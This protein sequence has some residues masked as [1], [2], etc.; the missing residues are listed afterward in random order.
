MVACSGGADSTALACALAAATDRL[1]IAHVV[2][3]LRPRRAALRD[4]DAVRDL[5]DRL[6]VPCVEA[7]ITP[8]AKGGNA[9]GAARGM[10]YDALGRLAREHGCGFIATAH[11][12]D[13]QLESMLMALIRGAG[14][15]GLQGVAV[16]RRLPGGLTLIRPALGVTRAQ[17]RS[18]CVRLGHAWREDRS[19]ADTRRLRAALRRDVLPVLERLRPGAA[20][21]AARTAALLRDASRLMDSAGARLLRRAGLPFALKSPSRKHPHR[22]DAEAGDEVF[23]LSRDVLRAAPGA[24]LGTALRLAFSRLTGGVGLDRLGARRLDP[25]VDAVGSDS[26]PPRRFEWP[27]GVRVV[28][29]AAEVTIAR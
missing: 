13:D 23:T 20:L 2:H 24:V 3:D 15:R 1:V 21:R 22:P 27:L 10:R 11:H 17:T 26:T 19:N 29:G 12:A 18:L 25:V 6:G 7:E 28:V 5:A 9:E 16:S 14:P 4:R 8:R